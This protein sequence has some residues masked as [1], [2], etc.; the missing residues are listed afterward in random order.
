MKDIIDRFHAGSSD[1]VSQLFIKDLHLSKDCEKILMLRYC[2][3][4]LE[5]EL[6]DIYNVDIRT[7]QQRLSDAK[8]QV[9]LRIM[10]TWLEKYRCK[11]LEKQE[12]IVPIESLI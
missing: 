11:L 6:A 8:H 3:H 4:K 9:E 1:Q 5:K 12:E 10:A 2:H 7:V